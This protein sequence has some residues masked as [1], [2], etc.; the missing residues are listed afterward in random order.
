MLRTCLHTHRLHTLNCL[1]CPFARKVGVSAKA[2]LLLSIRSAEDGG[3][4]PFP[5]ATSSRSSSQIHPIRSISVHVCSWLIE[6]SLHR[7]QSNVDSFPSEFLTHSHTSGVHQCTV[8]PIQTANAVNLLGRK[9]E[10]S[11]RCS[12]I[13][14]RR[15]SGNVVGV[16]DTQ[17]TIFQ[18]ESREID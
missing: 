17:R 4:L 11:L 1:I 9:L 16:S 18:A 6:S 12:D 7:S 14:S 10:I 8:E 3:R 2:V 15:E 13:D 5:I